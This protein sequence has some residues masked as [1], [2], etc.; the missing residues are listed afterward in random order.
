MQPN[1][2]PMFKSSV[3]ASSQSSLPIRGRNICDQNLNKIKN[4]D[5]SLSAF[6]FLFSELIQRTQSRVTG[7]QDFEERL[8]EHGFRV[9]QR[10][11]ELVVW[12]ERSPKRETRVLGILQFIHSSLWKQLF[13]KHADSLEKSKDVNDEYMIVDNSPVF[14]KFISV[15][16]NMNQLNCCAY[17]AGIVEGFLTS[18]QFPCK[19]TA[20]TVPLPSYPSRTV[21]LVKLHSSVL[22]REEYL[23]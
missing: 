23:G 12:R 18:A 17:L 15:P 19:A 6:A 16:K 21:I 2:K 8:N 13:G 11:V 5:V 22:R 3:S 4:S 10:L 1:G 20:H 7:I 9:G 14:N